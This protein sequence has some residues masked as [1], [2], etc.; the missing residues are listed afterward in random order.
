MESLSNIAVRDGGFE[1]PEKGKKR[2]SKSKSKSK[3]KEVGPI[4]EEWT[5]S[6]EEE[7]NKAYFENLRIHYQREA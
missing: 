1:K 5:E 6:D 7:Y 2:K 4:M 3:K